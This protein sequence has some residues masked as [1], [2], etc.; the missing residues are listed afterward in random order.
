MATVNR[1]YSAIAQDTT[2]ST[3]ATSG[4][5]TIAVSSTTGWPSSYPF[6]LALDFG[7]ALEELVDVTAL[8]GLTATV[9]RGVDSTTAVGHA[10][11]A[12]VRHVITARDIREAEQHISFSTGVHGVTGAV[13]GTTDVQVVTNKDMTSI[14]N[15]FPA[16]W[17]NRNPN[18]C[19]DPHQQDPDCS[20]H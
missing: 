12:V 14:T 7:T 2:L 13:V 4:D 8:V 3:S 10:A 9:T 6:C 18:W 16:Q 20:Y 15:T 5:V 17:Y 19:S 1:Y 11:A